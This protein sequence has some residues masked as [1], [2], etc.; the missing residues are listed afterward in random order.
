MEWWR[1]RTAQLLIRHRLD[2]VVKPLTLFKLAINGCWPRFENGCEAFPAGSLPWLIE[3]AM[4]S[5]TE[6]WLLQH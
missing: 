1:N 4:S 2:E 5:G 3:H 6:L